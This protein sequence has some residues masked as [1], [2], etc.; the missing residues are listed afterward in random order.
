M[1]V[2]SKLH[3]LGVA[4]VALVLTGGTILYGIGWGLLILGLFI[5][6][7]VA[8]SFRGPRQ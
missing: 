6:A 5:T 8:F 4:G 2:E 3:L 7:F 1:S